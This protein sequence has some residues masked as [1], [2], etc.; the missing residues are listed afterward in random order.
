MNSGSLYKGRLAGCLF[1]VMVLAVS[2]A[3]F[4]DD[5]LKR[6]AESK[7]RAALAAMELLQN[8]GGWGNAWT[9][10]G[11]FM[12]GEYRIIP[13][14]WITVQPPATPGIAK[15]F[16][17]A[18][19]LL[20]DKGYL[21]RVYMARDALLAI[22]TPDGGFPYEADPKGQRPNQSVFDDDTTTGALDF[23][24]AVWQFT[25]ADAD[26]KA[27]KSVGDF[28]LKSQYPD[29]GGWPQRYPALMG[30]Y[31]RDITFND[32]AMQDII[33]ALLRLHELTNDKRYLDGTLKGGE[34]VIRL[35]GGPGE[36][37]WAAQYNP[38]T[39]KPAWARKF[40]PPSYSSFES[41]EVCNVL[42]DLY[43]NTGQ[44]RF[45][46]PLPKAFAW[47][48]AHRLP[49]G[50]WARF[51]EAGTQRPVYGHPTE[52]IPVYDV[53][54]AR[55]GYGWQGQWFP[56]EAKKA[57]ER[58]KAVGR[59]AYA[60]ELSAS[61]SK[62]KPEE[63]EPEVKRICGELTPQGW[64][65]EPPD[66]DQTN[67]M[68]GM[69]LPEQQIITSGAFCKNAEFLLRYL[70][71]RKGSL[72]VGPIRKSDLQFRGNLLAWNFVIYVKR[73]RNVAGKDSRASGGNAGASG[74]QTSLHRGADP[75]TKRRNNFEP[76]DS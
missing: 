37:I 25:K 15:V 72:T 30:T 74:M 10:D 33:K 70:E 9:Q 7:L 62:P 52:A 32:N 39:L 28:L 76:A 19:I 47:Y 6:T 48:D 60:K 27:V 53:A 40:E 45:L 73:C 16:L 57:Y 44:D 14:G 2:C 68:K 75:S 26:L 56:A 66:Y 21:E 34:C 11:R 36:E 23:L 31:M 54:E 59:D 20:N 49:N 41:I 67:E 51:Y 5:S 12:W 55:K 63:L 61:V 42:I 64:W 13:P 17:H 69:K 29:S 38:D 1:V 71:C 3:A 24:I 22:Q 46:E 58:I 50:L 35:Q 8:N 4:G 65:L 18:G 43:M